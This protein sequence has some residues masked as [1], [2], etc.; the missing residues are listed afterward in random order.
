M[1]ID[2]SLWVEKYRPQVLDEYV[3]N[4]HI[5]NKFKEYI[6]TND[7]PHV[8]MF[9]KA[10]TGKTTL[11]R[12]LTNNIECDELYINASDETGVDIVRTKIKPFAASVSFAKIKVVI[13]DEFDYM[14]PNSQ[15]AL[16]N[17]MEQFSKITRF[18]LTCNYRERI[19]DPIISRS[20]VYEVF[21]PS[22]K[23]VAIHVAKI[24][25]EEKVTFNPED[26]KVLVD[27]TYPDIRQLINVCQRNSNDGKL[28]V[29]RA[30]II[31]SDFKLKLLEILTQKEKKDIFRSIR[32]LVAN[33]HISDFT[34]V[35]KFLYEKVDEYAP[36]KVP[37]II[38]KVANG[39][40]YDTYVVDKEI[41]FMS[42]IIDMLSV[43]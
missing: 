4:E 15:A 42:T 8:L 21:P 12:V 1:A 5:K 23:E 19:I 27:S 31:D 34:E 43:L 30:E 13:L 20:Q 40:R 41:N 17:I 6:E 22:R 9:G 37:H 18:I 26:I 2:N 3:G 25:K 33:N 24:L 11:A 32:Q 35:Y 28:V 29:N 39:L 7:L 36:N 14:S 38:E 10:G 16:R